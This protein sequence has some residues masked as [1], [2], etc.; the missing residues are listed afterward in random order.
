M[1]DLANLFRTGLTTLGGRYMRTLWH[2]IIIAARSRNRDGRNRFRYSA[3]SLRSIAAKAV[4]RILP[5]FAA[6]IA[7]CNCRSAG[8]RREVMAHAEGRP[9]KKGYRS[10]A[11]IDSEDE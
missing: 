8:S 7:A 10:E 3:R 1:A 6:P 5:R 9:L 11:V 2:P 4:R